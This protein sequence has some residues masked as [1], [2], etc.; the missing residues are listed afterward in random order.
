MEEEKKCPEKYQ[1]FSQLMNQKT[2]IRGSIRMV[3][4]C[5]GWHSSEYNEYSAMSVQLGGHPFCLA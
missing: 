2:A 1:E 3:A 5:A 4:G